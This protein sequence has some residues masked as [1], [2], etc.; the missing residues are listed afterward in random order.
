MLSIIPGAADFTA[1]DLQK[2]RKIGG[3]FYRFSHQL[4]EFWHN[5]LRGNSAGQK[6]QELSDRSQA[7]RLLN[8]ASLK[9]DMRRR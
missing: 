3:L 5:P 2:G 6:A 4:G 9:A 1:A 7:R 8:A